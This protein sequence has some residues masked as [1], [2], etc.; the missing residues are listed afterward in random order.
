MT[1]AITNNPAALYPEDLFDSPVQHKPWLV[2]HVKSRREKT[3]AGY[4]ADADIGY[5]LP[6]YQRRQASTKRVRYSLLPLSNGYLFFRGDDVDRHYAM[7]SNQIAR[8]IDVRDQDRL[9]NELQSI[10]RV[11]ANELPVYPYHY[12][13]EGERVRVKKGLLKDIEGIVERKAKNYRLVISVEAINQSM[14][15]TID[16]DMVEPV[17]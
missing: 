1:T 9:S 14:A 11:L 3:L 7:R 8:V 5:Y 2:A 13:A 16:A 17:R 12:I 6:M 15:V 4:L 10:R